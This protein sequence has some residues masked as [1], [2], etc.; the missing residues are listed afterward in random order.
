MLC[1]AH[2]Q[3][4]RALV[5]AVAENRFHI[6]LINRTWV[7]LCHVSGHDEARGLILPEQMGKPRLAQRLFNGRI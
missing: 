5:A 6:I 4:Y 3:E 2:W 1:E 7:T